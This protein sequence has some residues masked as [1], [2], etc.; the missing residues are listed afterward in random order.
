MA[1]AE[2]APGHSFF[3]M[4][5]SSLF[6]RTIFLNRQVARGK[7]VFALGS[8]NISFE[9]YVQSILHFDHFISRVNYDSP[10]RGDYEERVM[11]LG[12]VSLAR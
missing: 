6:R 5:V 9:Q 11:R 10:F 8:L 7:A 1:Q 2:D 4:L 3:S 12:L